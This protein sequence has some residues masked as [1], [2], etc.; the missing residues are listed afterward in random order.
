MQGNTN[1]LWTYGKVIKNKNKEGKYKFVV[2]L[3]KLDKNKNKKMQGKYKFVL[4]L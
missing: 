3:W 2:D 1:L 4:D